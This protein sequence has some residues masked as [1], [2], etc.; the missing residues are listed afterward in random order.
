MH[1]GAVRRGRSHNKAV[2]KRSRGFKRSDYLRNVGG[3]LTYRAV[4]TYYVRIFLIDNSVKRNR[5][6]T[7]LT[8]AD[9]KLA[10]TSAYRYHTV[11]SQNS[12]FKRL[13]NRSALHNG[14]GGT[15]AGKIVLNRQRL[16]VKRSADRVDNPA[17]K[18]IADRDFRHNP[19]SLYAVSDIYGIG[20]IH[21]HGS[22]AVLFKVERHS[23]S[24]ALKF[25]KL[26]VKAVGKPLYAH[27]TVADRRDS[28][29]AV[30]YWLNLKLG[31]TFF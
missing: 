21:K 8:V 18:R 5:G 27:N 6:F 9:N 4:Y 31:D 19:R 10:L 12:G 13:I 14:G 3:L 30:D 1:S 20:I 2:F 28:T 25:Q 7:R 29:A 16:S 11:D 23:V 24:S 26:A 15:L 22:N 17:Q